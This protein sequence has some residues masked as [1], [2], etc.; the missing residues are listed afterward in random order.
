LPV[1]ERVFAKEI[2]EIS[3]LVREDCSSDIQ[4]IELAKR[5]IDFERNESFLMNFSDEDAKNE[6]KSWELNPHRS[7]LIQLAQMHRNKQCVSVTFTT[8]NKKPKGK[9]CAEEIKFIEAFLKLQD[10]VLL[11]KLRGAQ[12]SQLIRAKQDRCQKVVP[13][14]IF[15]GCH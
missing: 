8:P 15:S 10:N 9:E 7:E 13:I 11:G 5:I 12:Q 4:A 6:I 3:L 1:D 2:A 14:W